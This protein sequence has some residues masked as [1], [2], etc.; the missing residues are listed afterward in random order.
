MG[1]HRFARVCNDMARSGRARLSMVRFGHE[2]AGS[3]CYGVGGYGDAGG[4]E[5]RHCAVRFGSLWS[6]IHRL[7]G[8]EFAD[9]GYGPGRK[10][11][12]VSCG[13]FRRA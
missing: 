7:G 11:G 4:A 8:V 9:V 13:M 2:S 5:A 1:K 12:L 10:A 6:G 3:V